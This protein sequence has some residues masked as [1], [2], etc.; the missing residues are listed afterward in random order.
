MQ[1]CGD[2]A[3][4]AANVEALGWELGSG[5]DSMAGGHAGL[6][7]RDQVGYSRTLL[8][9]PEKTCVTSVLKVRLTGSHGHTPLSL[10]LLRIAIL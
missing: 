6:L 10:P 4:R 7:P 9:S 8:P 5:G 2:R 3:F 1:V